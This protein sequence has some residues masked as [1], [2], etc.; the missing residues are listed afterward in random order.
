MHTS[1]G[2]EDKMYLWERIIDNFFKVLQLFF[3]VSIKNTNN[4]N[5]H[6]KPFLDRKE[7]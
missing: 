5:W 7:F 6:V 4:L 3:T 1:I 2:K